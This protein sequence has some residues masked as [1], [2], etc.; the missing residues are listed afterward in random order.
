[1]TDTCAVSNCLM[2]DV[3]GVCISTSVASV[4]IKLRHLLLEHKVMGHN[5]C[6]SYCQSHFSKIF[7]QFFLKF[8]IIY[9]YFP[10]Y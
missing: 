8:D 10:E 5:R 7:L 6:K 2:N 3:F 4:E 9:S 1:M